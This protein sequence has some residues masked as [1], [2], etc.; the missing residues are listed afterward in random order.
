[1]AGQ[2][3]LFEKTSDGLLVE[4]APADAE[5]VREGRAISHVNLSID[6]LWTAEEEATRAAEEAEA[7]NQ[8]KAAEEARVAAAADQAARRLAAEA[9]LGELGLTPDDLQALRG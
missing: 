2:V 6:I 4:V 9:K 5:R 1:M 8:A 7:A 3:R